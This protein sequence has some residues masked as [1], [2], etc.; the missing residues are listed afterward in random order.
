M[1]W[2]PSEAYIRRCRSKRRYQTKKQALI[3]LSYHLQ[4][5]PEYSEGLQIYRCHWCR[6]LHLGHRGQVQHAQPEPEPLP[7]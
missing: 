6:R 7:A 2:K 4:Y 5:H 3:A 1:L